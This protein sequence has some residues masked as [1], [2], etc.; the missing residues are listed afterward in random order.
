MEVQV[1]NY[2]EKFWE[3]QNRSME[4]RINQKVFKQ[5]WGIHSF[6]WKIRLELAGTEVGMNPRKADS[7]RAR[8]SLLRLEWAKGNMEDYFIF[9]SKTQEIGTRK[10]NIE[11][12]KSSRRP[13]RAGDFV[14]PKKIVGAL[15]GD[16]N[17]PQRHLDLIEKAQMSSRGRTNLE[18]PG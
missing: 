8:M 3:R 4:D 7:K 17:G 9:S 2:E 15:A 6:G 1:K 5:V 11:I 18:K 12:W 16:P 14:L 10:Y 13:D